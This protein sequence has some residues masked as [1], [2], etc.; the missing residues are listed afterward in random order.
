[1]KEN[2]INY[3]PLKIYRYLRWR[4]SAMKNYRHTSSCYGKEYADLCMDVERAMFFNWPLDR[5][6]EAC[7]KKDAYIVEYLESVCGDVIEAYKNRKPLPAKPDEK[8][9]I[10]VFWWSG[11][12]TAPEIVKA[13]IKSI[14]ENAAG[15][16]V[17]FLDESNYAQY[18]DIPQFLLEKHKKGLIGHAHF[19]DVVRL[20]LLAKY[21]GAW[22]DATVFISQPLPE[23]MFENSF[24]TL[25]TVDPNMHFYS[26]SRWCTYFLAGS[27]NFLLFS[28]VRDMMLEYWKKFD[29]IID[30][31]MMD[32]LIGIAYTHLPEVAEVMDRLPDN[33]TLRGKLM[34]A[35]N[36]P[37]DE[38][39]FSRLE[40]EDTF[41]SK[42]SW[43][44]GN[45]TA[46]TADGKLTNYGHLLRK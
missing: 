28:V 7:G 17:I 43:R 12:E 9:R 41:A 15:R 45:P 13:C 16:E 8:K 21:G 42:L 36:E 33:N 24:Y 11:E 23:V 14:R 26:K 2:L 37:Y 10:W 19:S 22:I 40:Q 39:L 6:L 29:V 35:I 44:Y 32:Y 34:E 1:M 31:L 25:K 18:V 46:Q 38:A 5:M 30:Y 20:S 27:S 3:I 4:R